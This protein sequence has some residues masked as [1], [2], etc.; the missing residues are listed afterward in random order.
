MSRT[1]LLFFFLF[2][3]ANCL[4]CNLSNNTIIEG[5]DNFSLHYSLQ[6]S[7]IEASKPFTIQVCLYQKNT[8]FTQIEDLIFDASMPAHG[9]GMNYK[10]NITKLK[11]GVHLIEGLLLHMPGEWQF[12][13]KARLKNQNLNF[14]SHHS[15]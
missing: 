2:F 13:F 4:S 10:A 15:I 7:I 1:S 12:T 11:N 9:H 14:I 5:K 8:H 3:S 6:P